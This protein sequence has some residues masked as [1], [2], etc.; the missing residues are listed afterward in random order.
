MRSPDGGGRAPSMSPAIFNT[1]WRPSEYSSARSSA[2]SFE[3][4][5]RDSAPYT[6]A[7]NRPRM[8]MASRSSSNVN[9]SAPPRSAGLVGGVE[10]TAVANVVDQLARIRHARVPHHVHDDAADGGQIGVLD[11]AFPVE[12]RRIAELAARGAGVGELF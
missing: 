5:V 10:L 1:A 8:T 6:V 7:S 9:P 3:N 11:V 12:A 4:I 2:I